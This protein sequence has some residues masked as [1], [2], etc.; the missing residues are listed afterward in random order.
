[1]SEFAKVRRPKRGDTEDD[2]LEDMRKFESGKASVAP[3]NILKLTKKTDEKSAA[4][5]P[6]KSKF[7]SERQLK[8]QHDADADGDA[9]PK[10]GLNFILKSV[11]EEKVSDYSDRRGFEPKPVTDQPFPEVVKVDA[12]VFEN[13]EPAKSGKRPSLFAQQMANKGIRPGM[14]RP[15]LFKDGSSVTIDFFARRSH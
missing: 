9:K 10:S 3:E 13:R 5:A 14:S 2:L 12:S 8:R 15:K 1:M 7:A 11:V 4:A 6:K